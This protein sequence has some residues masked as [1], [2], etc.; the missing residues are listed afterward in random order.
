MT[1]GLKIIQLCY[2]NLRKPSETAMHYRTIL[3]KISSV[4]KKR[5][6][7]LAL[8]EQ[9]S[10]GKVSEWF[11]PSEADFVLSSYASNILFPIRVEW[12]GADD[13]S[14]TGTEIPLVN[15]QALNE[16]YGAA[17]FYGSP[18]R[19]VFRDALETVQDRQFRIA[20]ETDFTDTV[21]TNQTVNL[22]EYF[23]D[24]VATEASILLLP[25][26]E[27]N[28]AEW[29]MFYKRQMPVLQNDYLDWAA[30]WKKFAQQFKGRSNV[31]KRTF[32]DRR[33]YLPYRIRR[34]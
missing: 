25:I 34:Y 27:D 23:T 10:L 29:D 21:D 14:E 8:S 33:N 12:R 5:K 18:L 15:Y 9:N 22:P 30:K 32:L 7:D 4:I 3:N 16:S 2:E 17:S 6:L 13:T 31:P 24:F 26:V 11:T 28:S 20:Y 19:M 1:Q